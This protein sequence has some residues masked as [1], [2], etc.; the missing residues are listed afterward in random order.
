MNIGKLLFTILIIAGISLVVFYTVDFTKSKSPREDYVE[1]IAEARRA[2]AHFFLNQ[3]DSPLTATQKMEFEG[4]S[5]FPI[6]PA[7][8]IKAEFS[9]AQNKDV[10]TLNY[11]DGSA[12]KYYLYGIARFPLQGRQ[13]ELQ[14]FKPVDDLA[15]DYLF[16]PFYDQTTGEQTY[17]GGRYVEPVL[18]DDSHLEIDFNMAY[19]P[20]CAYNPK[21]R[22]PI[23]PKENKM[24]VKVSAGEKNP[25]FTH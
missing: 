8:C 5:Y 13:Q 1:S 21:Y 6:D 15:Q 2:T 18:T 20:Y 10:R 7:F 9:I 16:L 4:L 17:G 23:P 19:N 12:R 22:C 14:V 25:D 24:T 3:E 11:T